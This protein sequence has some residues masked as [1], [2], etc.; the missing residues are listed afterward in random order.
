[1]AS[2][3]ETKRNDSKPSDSRGGRYNSECRSDCCMAWLIT[4]FKVIIILLLTLC[5]I[6]IMLDIVH[7]IQ[8]KD[9]YSKT[10]YL[11]EI[12]IRIV[13]IVT[14]LMLIVM[15]ACEQ[16][17]CIC[18][19]LFLNICLIIWE[20]YEAQQKNQYTEYVS[21]PVFII[22]LLNVLLLTCYSILICFG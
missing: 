2:R 1:M 6:A 18:I 4:V 15:V 12:I 16:A 14:Y 3:R 10:M 19:T 20:V 22:N 17:A 9:S 7:V 13:E 5:L 21:S 8:N 11:V